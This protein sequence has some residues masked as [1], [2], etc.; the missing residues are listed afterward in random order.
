MV[1]VLG[2]PLI[3]QFVFRLCVV[4]N[5]PVP[6]LQQ[7]VAIRLLGISSQNPIKIYWLI[8]PV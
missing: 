7:V 8:R 6:I 1:L 3:V 5:G 4:G 2:G